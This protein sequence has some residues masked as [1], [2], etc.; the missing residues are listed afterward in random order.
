MSKEVPG[1]TTMIQQM[2]DE[3]FGPRNR[4]I[5]ELSL[6]GNNTILWGLREREYELYMITTHKGK[7]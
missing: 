1:S 3:N 6:D 2:L 5:A 4:Q 7:T